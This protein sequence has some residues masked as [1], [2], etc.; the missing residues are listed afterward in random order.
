MFSFIYTKFDI[1]P[2]GMKIHIFIA[3]YQ[4]RSKNLEATDM[5]LLAENLPQ[6]INC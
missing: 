2:L 4:D 5:Q 1:Q 3:N 6:L